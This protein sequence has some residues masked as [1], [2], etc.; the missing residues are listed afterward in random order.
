MDIFISKALGPERQLS[1]GDL[2]RG[3]MV[4]ISHEL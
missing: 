2:F 1:L 3:S 4:Q